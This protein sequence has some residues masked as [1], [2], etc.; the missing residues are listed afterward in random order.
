MQRYRV[1]LENLE[2]K[3]VQPADE[4]KHEGDTILEERVGETMFLTLHAE[5][6]EA[7]REKANRVASRIKA[8]SSAD[9]E[10]DDIQQTMMQTGIGGQLGDRSGTFSEE[11][12]GSRSHTGIGGGV[13]A[14]YL[15]AAAHGDPTKRPE[16]EADGPDETDYL[17]PDDLIKGGKKS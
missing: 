2:I 14:D 13:N 4:P 5:S 11:E 1:E 17:D 9:S 10:A 15:R 16:D 6:E 7:A 8:N 3:S 12:P